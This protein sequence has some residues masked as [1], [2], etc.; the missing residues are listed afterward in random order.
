MNSG[1]RASLVSRLL[2][3]LTLLLCGYDFLVLLAKVCLIVSSQYAL[4]FC[5][6]P[7]T[8]QNVLFFVVFHV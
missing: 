4:V 3:Y 1:L 7:F 5:C 8:S 2:F 6:P